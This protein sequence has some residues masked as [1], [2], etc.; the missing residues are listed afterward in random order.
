MKRSHVVVVRIA[1]IGFCSICTICG[2]WIHS[3]YTRDTLERAEGELHCPVCNGT[4]EV[5]EDTVVTDIQTRA[6]AM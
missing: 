4:L 5:L 2:R 1:A 6:A 3:R